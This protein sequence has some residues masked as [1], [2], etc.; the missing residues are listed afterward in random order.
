[1]RSTIH[2][3]RAQ[4]PQDLTARA[5]PTVDSIDDVSA[6]LQTLLEALSGQT[7]CL[8]A[9]DA[10]TEKL[11]RS[12]EVGVRL[13]G[14]GVGAVAVINYGGADGARGPGDEIR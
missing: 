7:K 14:N 8:P 13:P 5:T 10:D 12:G 9:R 2:R 11:L 3:L 6:E 1:M 4:F